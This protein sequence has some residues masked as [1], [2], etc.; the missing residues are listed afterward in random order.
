MYQTTKELAEYSGDNRLSPE[1]S[2]LL[3][4]LTCGLYQIYWWYRIADVFMGAQQRANMPRLSDNK[5]LFVV[6][7]LFGFDFINMA[8]LQ[9]DMNQMWEA[10]DQN[11]M[12]SSATSNDSSDS[13]DWVDY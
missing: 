13:D 5:I 6:L 8:I 10:A 9:G 11:V 3:S 4:I 7:S 12:M 1:T 2:I